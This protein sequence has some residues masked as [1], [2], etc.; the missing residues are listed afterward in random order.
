MAEISNGYYLKARSIQH[1]AISTA[2]PH[3]REIWDY[4]LRE[5]NHSDNKYSGFEVKR[6][7]LFRTY[8]DIREALH[9][10]VGYRKMMYSENHTKKAMKFLREHLMITTRKELGGVLITVLNYAKYQDPKNYERTNERTCE[11]TNAEPM[12]NHTI[13]DNNK[14]VRIKECKKKRIKRSKVSEAETPDTLCKISGCRDKPI[15]GRDMCAKHYPMNVEK[16]IEWYRKSPL[17]HIRLIAEFTDELYQHGNAPEFETVAQWMEWTDGAMMKWAKK[18]SVFTDA[19]LGSA[20]KRMTGA[21][22]ITEF[23]LATLSKFVK[24]IKK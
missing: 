1:S 22:Y 10:Q 16:F 8:K 18:L 9:W 6:G 20:M 17:R 12:R 4:L 5:A 24:N 19:Q 7:Q 23:N 15:R 13:P 21:N 2:P 11:R 14:N 3:I